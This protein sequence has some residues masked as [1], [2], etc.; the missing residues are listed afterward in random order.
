MVAE[1]PMAKMC[2][3][4]VGKYFLRSN[5]ENGPTPSQASDRDEAR[6]GPPVCA[7]RFTFHN[8]FGLFWVFH[9]SCERFFPGGGNVRAS[10]ARGLSLVRPMLFSSV[11]FAEDFQAFLGRVCGDGG[12]LFLV[13]GGRGGVKHAPSYTGLPMCTVVRI[14]WQAYRFN[15]CSMRR[16][17]P[18]HVPYQGP[19]R[20]R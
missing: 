15:L 20:T 8:L 12:R 4:Q 5:L 17:S 7:K 1:R 16:F 11:R 6:P 18:K 2:S 10:Q 13:T 3:A 19:Y 14:A 9:L